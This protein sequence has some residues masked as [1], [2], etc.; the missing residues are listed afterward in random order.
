[1]LGAISTQLLQ[2]LSL[3]THVHPFDWESQ[4]LPLN[5]LNAYVECAQMWLFLLCRAVCVGE[6]GGRSWMTGA[7]I[8]KTF[9]NRSQIAGKLLA[10]MF[11][12]RFAR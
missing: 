12:K 11:A 2:I 8:L 1:M 9:A 3:Q 6:Q 4:P 10:K 5:G 7:K